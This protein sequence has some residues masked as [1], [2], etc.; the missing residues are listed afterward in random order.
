MIS[1]NGLASPL[2]HGTLGSYDA[3]ESADSLG[4][5]TVWKHAHFVGTDSESTLSVS[6]LGHLAKL[7]RYLD[8]LVWGDRYPFPAEAVFD[9]ARSLA[10]HGEIAQPLFMWTHILPPHDPYWPPADFR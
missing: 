10:E 2:Q 7:G 6:V 3:V 1:S 5:Y 8:M 4:T 9:Q